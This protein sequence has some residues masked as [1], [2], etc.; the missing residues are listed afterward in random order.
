MSEEQLTN[1][2]PIDLLIDTQYGQ[3][4]YRQWCSEDI[5]RLM[6]G[7]VNMREFTVR[8]QD[9]VLTGM[10]EA[11]RCC[12]IFEYKKGVE[13]DDYSTESI[14]TGANCDVSEL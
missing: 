5:P 10:K 1:W 11:V 9:M 14:G 8:Y 2:Q 13:D 4:T 12:A 7:K 3:M 6:E